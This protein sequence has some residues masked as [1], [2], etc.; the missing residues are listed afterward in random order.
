VQHWRLASIVENNELKLQKKIDMLGSRISKI[1]KALQEEA[2][3]LNN[4]N[5]VLEAQRNDSKRRYLE[6]ARLL[7]SNRDK[8]SK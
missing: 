4:M 6:I 2:Y 5:A 1:E 3:T 8:I 7:Q